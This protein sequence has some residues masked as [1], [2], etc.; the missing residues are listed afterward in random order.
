[1][2][3]IYDYTDYRAFLRDYFTQHAD[4]DSGK[5]SFRAVAQKAGFKSPNYLQKIIGGEKNLTPASALGLAKGLHLSALEQKYFVKLVELQKASATEAKQK[6]LA[7]MSQILAKTHRSKVKDTS[8]YSLWTNFI[9][10]EM[11]NIPDILITTESVFYL[12][13]GKA[14]R[15]EIEQSIKYLTE[16][17]LLVPGDKPDNYKPRPVDFE[18]VNDKRMIEI[19]QNHLRFL[20]IAKHRTHEALSDS[21]FQAL[22]IAAPNNKI[23]YIRKRL[24]AFLDE[25]NEELTEAGTAET[26]LQIQCQAFKLI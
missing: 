23:D 12:L 9:I 5:Y 11:A 3:R 1:M 15:Q 19:Q 7:E 17:K 10:L 22:T 6:I 14:S 25:L 21:V 16:R 2:T 20:D 24:S 8:V 13:R 18:A 4:Q 26:V